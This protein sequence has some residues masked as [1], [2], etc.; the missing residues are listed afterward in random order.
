MKLGSGIAPVTRYLDKGITVALGSDGAG[1]NN[2]LDILREI[3]TAALLHKVTGDS[4]AVNALQALQMATSA[5]AQALRLPDLGYLAV[6]QLADVILL[7]FTQPHLQPG[8]RIISNLVYAAA[9]GDVATV[10]VH[11]KILVHNGELTTLDLKQ[12]YARVE[13][14]VNRLFK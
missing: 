3:R 6:G 13:E 4:T 2:T 9:A 8:G 11:G 14:S 12:I 1:S 7:D 5:G 10:I